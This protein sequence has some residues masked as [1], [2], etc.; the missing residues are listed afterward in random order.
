MF[1]SISPGVNELVNAHSAR[2]IRIHISTTTPRTQSI[3]NPAQKPPHKH[4]PLF[5]T[6]TRIRIRT[7]IRNSSSIP[8]FRLEPVPAQRYGRWPG[9][10]VEP[11]PF[12][13][14]VP[15]LLMSFHAPPIRS[16]PISFNITANTTRSS[17]PVHPTPRPLAR[18]QTQ[19]F[20]N[21][22]LGIVKL[23]GWWRDVVSDARLGCYE[24]VQQ[25]YGVDQGLE[26]GV[27]ELREGGAVYWVWGVSGG[28]GVGGFHFRF[29]VYV[30]WDGLTSRVQI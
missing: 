18:G 6:R 2:S 25:I 23:P 28:V 20:Y 26:D 22:A 5:R 9:C 3:T 14:T 24:C 4:N 11:H 19:R 10:D 21:R 13:H 27:C 1:L 15:A 8:L 17:E 7:R 12:P 16:T 29:E 30:A